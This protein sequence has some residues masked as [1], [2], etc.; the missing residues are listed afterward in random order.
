MQ[1]ITLTRQV[2]DHNRLAKKTYVRLF[3]VGVPSFTGRN[4]L[5]VKM[6]MVC[7]TQTPNILHSSNMRKSQ[8]QLSASLL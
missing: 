6:F 5:Q 4:G 3:G 2:A 8:P 7:G 1:S